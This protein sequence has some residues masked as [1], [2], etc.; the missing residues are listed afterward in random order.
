MFQSLCNLVNNSAANQRQYAWNHVKVWDIGHTHESLS[1]RKLSN[2][3]VRLVV[4][5]DPEH[6]RDI[7][8]SKSGKYMQLFNIGKLVGVKQQM[9]SS[10]GYTTVWIEF[11]KTK[12]MIAHC[13]VEF[14]LGLLAESKP[15]ALEAAASTSRPQPQPQPL[16]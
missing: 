4:H 2:G 12:K 6:A 5:F 10:G 1:I 7:F 15:T 16:R 11:A 13:T 3:G 9:K 14:L 8:F